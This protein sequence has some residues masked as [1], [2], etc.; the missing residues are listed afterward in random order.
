[1]AENPPRLSF[2]FHSIQTVSTLFDTRISAHALLT[3]P[4]TGLPA[5]VVSTLGLSLV[6][7][8]TSPPSLPIGSGPIFP[9]LAESL[10]P[11]LEVLARPSAWLL[12]ERSLS[13]KVLQFSRFH[14]A[15][16]KLLPGLM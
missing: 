8:S 7:S 2:F 13:E 5:T 11:S 12:Q 9:K 15:G 3:W 6:G 1:M 4:F 10:V 16:I 14:I